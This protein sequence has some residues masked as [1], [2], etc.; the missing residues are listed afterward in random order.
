MG[1]GRD[2]L[3]SFVVYGAVRNLTVAH[4]RMRHATGL[5]GDR[6]SQTRLCKPK[7]VPRQGTLSHSGRINWNDT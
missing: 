6:D 3:Q 5:A 4:G 7:D 2:I 1:I